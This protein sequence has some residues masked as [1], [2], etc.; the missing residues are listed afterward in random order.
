VD[1]TPFAAFPVEPFRFTQISADFFDN[2]HYV[3]GRRVNPP[4]AHV[5]NWFQP[6]T[7]RETR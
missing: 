7:A 1:G 4:T 5:R 3:E 2:Q 6:L